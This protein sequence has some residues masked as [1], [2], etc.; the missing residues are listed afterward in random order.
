MKNISEQ[1]AEAYAYCKR[2]TK[3]ADSNFALSFLFLPKAKKNAIYAV[4]AFNRCADDFADEVLSTHDSMEKLEKWEYMLDE[5]YRGK[6]SHP[7]MIAFTDA[8]QRYNIPKKPFQDAIKGFKMD[9]S[10]NRYKTF[11]DLKKYC[12]LVAGTISTISLHIFGFL[13]K[14]AFEFGKHLSYALQLT[15]IIRDIGKDI[16]R[17]R[18]YMPLDELCRFE[19]TE[20]DLLSR[21]NNDKFYRLMRFQI[22]RAQEFYKKANPLIRLIPRDTRFTVVM[23]GAVYLRLLKKISE[24]GIPA[25]QR[26]VRLT[27]WDKLKVIGKMHVKP[28]FL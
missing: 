17:N 9:L 11:D 27:N 22:E 12:D 25:L 4:Y 23:I 19:Y 3:K 16:D 8:I 28:T 21:R 20:N 10:I 15:N 14:K 6:A 24:C 1:T 7:V 26:V 2:L 5:C 18:I 13:D